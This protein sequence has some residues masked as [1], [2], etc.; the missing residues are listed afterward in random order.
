LE[1]SGAIVVHQG[2]IL[3]AQRGKGKYDYLSFVYEFPGGKL[4]E[5][6]TPKEALGR[7]LVEEMDL[8]IPQEDMKFFYTVEHQYPDFHLTMHTFICPVSSPEI[9]LKEHV[10]AVWLPV[11]ELD[12]LNWA[13]ADWPIIEELKNERFTKEL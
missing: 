9:K 12:S 10:E 6:E 11:S 4:E 1:V 5:G 7:E 13:P 2:K 3:C 8:Q